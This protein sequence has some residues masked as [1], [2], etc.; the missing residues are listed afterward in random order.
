MQAADP[1]IL[2]VQGIEHHQFLWLGKKLR[3]PPERI[4]RIAILRAAYQVMCNLF[5]DGGKTSFFRAVLDED[6]IAQFESP[7]HLAICAGWEPADADLEEWTVEDRAR[8]EAYRDSWAAYAEEFV[9]REGEKRDRV[10]LR[11]YDRTTGKI[12]YSTHHRQ[13]QQLLVRAWLACSF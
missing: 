12:L 3:L 13:Q 11:P 5:P 4:I 7:K 10:H 6:G 2:I 8:A 9:R 1:A